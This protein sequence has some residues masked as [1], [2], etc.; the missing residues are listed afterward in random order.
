VRGS[1]VSDWAV[2]SPTEPPRV[3]L[4]PVFISVAPSSGRTLLGIL[5]EQRIA[6]TVE[7]NRRVYDSSGAFTVDHALLVCPAGTV[8]VQ[9]PCA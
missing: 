3:P 1:W 8:P 9:L 6:N 4:R 5:T 2:G 7:T